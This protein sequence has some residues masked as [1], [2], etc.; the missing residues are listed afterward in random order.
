MYID[1]CALQVDYYWLL[2]M[3]NGALKVKF[4]GKNHICAK[5]PAICEEVYLCEEN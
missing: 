2:L 4:Q 1:T 3:F 5:M